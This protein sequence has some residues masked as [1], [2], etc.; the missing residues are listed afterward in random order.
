MPRENGRVQRIGQHLPLC[1][2]QKLLHVLAPF[3][4]ALPDVFVRDVEI[5][6]LDLHA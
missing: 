3:D 1:R 4:H 5:V 6:R 2:R